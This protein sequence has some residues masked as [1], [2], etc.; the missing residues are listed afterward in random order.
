MT[1]CEN[2]N[3]QGN[4]EC[5]SGYSNNKFKCGTSASFCNNLSLS[6]KFMFSLYWC[7]MF[8]LKLKF[9]FVIFRIL[10]LTFNYQRL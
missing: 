1:S 3:C 6:F 5:C 4:N 2:S 8:S 9:P 10:N 7:L